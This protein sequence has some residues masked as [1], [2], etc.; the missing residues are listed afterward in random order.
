MLTNLTQKSNKST[1]RFLKALLRHKRHYDFVRNV[2]EIEACHR[3]QDFREDIQDICEFIRTTE[4]CNG[5]VGIINYLE[6]CVCTLKWDV[7]AMWGLPSLAVGLM[8]LFIYIV[9]LY[10]NGRYF[11]LPNCIVLSNYFNMRNYDFGCVVLGILF[12]LP[13][14]L[15][16]IFACMEYNRS[17]SLLHAQTFGKMFTCFVMGLCLVSYRGSYHFNGRLFRRDLFFLTISTVYLYLAISREMINENRKPHLKYKPMIHIHSYIILVIY[18][19]FLVNIIFFSKP[20]KLNPSKIS[21]PNYI[22]SSSE[23]MESDA[24]P[25]VHYN[26]VVKDISPGILFFHCINPSKVLKHHILPLR[27]LMFPFYVLYAI[28]IPV[29]NRERLLNGWCK[30]IFCCSCLGF[31]LYAI[32]LQFDSLTMLFLALQGIMATLLVMVLTHAQR[33]PTHHELLSLWG[34]IIGFGI[35]NILDMEICCILWQFLNF[36]LNMD[37]DVILILAF[38]FCYIFVEG[39]FV[40][41]LMENG[42]REMALGFVMG[43]VLCIAYSA[44]PVML[45]SVCFSSDHVYSLTD[46][47]TTAFYFMI[48]V[49]CVTLV[50]F[51]LNGYELRPSCSAFFGIVA[52]VFTLYMILENEDVI[53]AYGTIHS[54]TIFVDISHSQWA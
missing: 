4:S 39:I 21:D 45:F 32:T 17:D 19:G 50:A 37:N 9:N 25:Y 6:F 52:F 29:V 3:R 23:S 5:A 15:T 27:I 16:M 7:T 31:P 20:K 53:H 41:T 48:I 40:V 34:L 44:L 11:L 43:T 54:Q 14:N 38:P 18:V 10:I 1:N 36:G 2:E 49:E 33:I 46:N 47:T 30:F 28:F 26:P 51:S 12:T 42:Y 24:Y 22:P 35:S 8:I 13:Y